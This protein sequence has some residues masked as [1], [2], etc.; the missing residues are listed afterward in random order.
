VYDERNGA[1]IL[2]SENMN[3]HAKDYLGYKIIKYECVTITNF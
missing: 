3:M 2:R 1:I